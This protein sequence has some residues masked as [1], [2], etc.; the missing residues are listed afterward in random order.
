MQ[1]CRYREVQLGATANAPS[2]E[3]IQLPHGVRYWNLVDDYLRLRKDIFVDDKA[4][5]LFHADGVEFEQYD[6]LDT[7]YAIASRG[8]RVIGG[9]RLRRCDWTTGQ[10]AYNYS[11]MVRDAY[12]GILPGLPSDLT[13]SEPPVSPDVWELTRFT[14]NR[15]AEL[16]VML[17]RSINDYLFMSGARSCICLGSPAFLR[18]ARRLGW[19]VERLGPERGDSTGKFLTFSFS[20]I[21]PDDLQPEGLINAV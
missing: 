9:A 7:V 3:I 16:V 20:V 11:Y 21:D 17:L 5:S 13:Y 1:V 6:T 10:G 15:D 12:R 2:V 4:W 18:V 19:P 8:S 14:V